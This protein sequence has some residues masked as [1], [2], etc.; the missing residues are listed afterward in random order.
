MH[1]TGSASDLAVI[2]L[3]WLSMLELV[4]SFRVIVASQRNTHAQ[5]IEMN[6]GFKA[7]NKHVRMFYGS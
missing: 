1:I 7:L 6:A 2:D 5:V 4:S 3:N